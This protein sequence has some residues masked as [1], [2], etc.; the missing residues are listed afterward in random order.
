MVQETGRIRQGV[1]LSMGGW[2]VG[3]RLQEIRDLLDAFG[4][5]LSRLVA[6][7]FALLLG[8][9]LGFRVDVEEGVVVLVRGCKYKLVCA[10]SPGFQ[11]T[12]ASS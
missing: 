5:E 7:G 4:E 6:L 9:V 12:Y 2:R 8:R 1:V 10:S 3:G 11:N